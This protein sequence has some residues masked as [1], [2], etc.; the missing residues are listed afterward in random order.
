M[1]LY[2]IRANGPFEYDKFILNIGQ[3]HNECSE[4]KKTYKESSFLQKDKDLTI[5]IQEHIRPIEV[6]S[7][8]IYKSWSWKTDK[9]TDSWLNQLANIR[10]AVL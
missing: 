10:R 4:I 8:K 1:I 9:E 5:Y 3:L 7:N 6:Y 2:N